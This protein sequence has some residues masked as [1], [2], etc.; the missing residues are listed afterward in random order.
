MP[1]KRAT[2]VI[3]ALLMLC[4]AHSANA[5]TRSTSGMGDVLLFPFYNTEMGWDTYIN[6]SSGADLIRR[7]TLVLRLRVLDGQHGNV[8][9]WFQ[10]YTG[11][12][13]NLRIALSR[14]PDGTS[15]LSIAEGSCVLDR[16]LD[17]GGAGTLFTGLPATGMVEVYLLGTVDRFSP[18]GPAPNRFDCQGVRDRW[19]E[20]GTWAIDPTVDFTP[21]ETNLAMNLFGE[22]YLVNVEEGLAATYA[23]L[24]LDEFAGM[25]HDSP[26]AD[27]VDL[28][29][30]DPR[31]T[32]IGTDDQILVASGI[33]AVAELLATQGRRLFNSVVNAASIGA[34]TDWVITYP[35]QPYLDTKPLFGE[36]NGEERN[37]DSFGTPD[38]SGI[39]T[40]PSGNFSLR[41]YGEDFYFA[42]DPRAGIDFL[43][44][45]IPGEPALCN[46]V[47]IIPFATNS[48][49]APMN[50]P[51]LTY[52]PEELLT[53]AADTDS[54]TFSF[55]PK[56]PNN[57]FGFRITTFRNGTLDGG[58]TLANYAVIRPHSIAE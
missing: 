37:C 55:R 4:L 58:S 44:P 22:S 54:Y 31:Y 42:T 14:A 20:G 5:V 40:L 33:D 50:S 17:G 36:I 16:H 8:S 38:F 19:T 21:H 39:F 15:D 24:A 7:E 29:V 53:Q 56:Y 25:D 52:P 41:A 1:L 26:V 51:L 11:P 10:V 35:L 6:V 45:P 28:T 32:P 18:T 34:S 46:A 23:P 13:A 9:D 48:V 3:A 27:T 47:N 43:H 57:T 2:Q 12:S 30:A 49:L